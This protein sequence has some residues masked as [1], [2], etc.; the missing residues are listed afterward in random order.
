MRKILYFCFSITLSCGLASIGTNN[1]EKQLK[2]FS[3]FKDG[4]YTKEGRIDLHH[5]KTE[6]DKH[7]N[8]LEK[9]LRVEQSVL[10]QFKLYSSTLAK[11]ECGHTQIHPTKSVLKEWLSTRNSLPIDFYLMNDR[12][13]VGKLH[14]ED[15]KIIF[16]GKSEYE[17]KK[18]I[19]EGSEILSI[20]EK[21]IPQIMEGISQFLSSDEDH[22]AFKYYQASQMFDFYR[23]LSEP[24]AKDS[25]EVI[26][27]H[28]KDTNTIF[29]QTGTAPVHSMNERLGKSAEKY[30]QEEEEFG[31]FTISRKCGYF[32]FTSFKNSHGKKYNEFLEKSFKKMKSRKIKKM[33]V[34][35]RGNT[36]G[37][38][39]Y[40]FLSYV[41]G[42][43]V[44]LGRYVVEKP[45]QGVENVHFKKLHSDY[46]KHRRMSNAQKRLKRK[47]KFND[48]MIKT[49][50]VNPE[51][52][53]D[54][55]IVVITDFGTFSSG[56]MIACHL[57]TLA[58]A[59]I[60]GHTPGGSFYKGNAGTLILKLPKSGLKLFI[61]PNT[62]YSQL[63]PTIDHIAIKTPDVKLNNLILDE[64]KR[65]AY[66]FKQ[67]IKAFR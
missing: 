1:P 47:G 36:G 11:I 32:R 26:Y 58:N 54:G 53:F 64:K 24:F 56:S 6:F 4:I 31:K 45:K 55:E 27:I 20:D 21:T 18:E 46:R 51:L 7:I 61:N 66:Y 15:K 35:V 48:G 62:F 40:A 12:L 39:Q 44:D 2:D 16:L 17:K 22:I 41:V 59:K 38:M 37:A 9:R 67:A 25:I 42:P 34:D 52:I 29:L 23:H 3:V 65:D 43:D 8:A 63:P 30:E 19:P 14:S 60:V 57:K 5:S 50:K 33:I 13:V 28:R 10:N 49:E